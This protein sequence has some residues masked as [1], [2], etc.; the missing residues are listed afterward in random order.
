[1]R[2]LCTLRGSVG[3][4]GPYLLD[5]YIPKERPQIQTK[6]TPLLKRIPTYLKRTEKYFTIPSFLK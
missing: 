6:Y 2:P 5:N 1:M 4:K 3:H